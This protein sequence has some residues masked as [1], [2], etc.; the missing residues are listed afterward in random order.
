M[1]SWH[2]F[3]SFSGHICNTL[4]CINL[5]RLKALVNSALSPRR[6]DDAAELLWSPGHS[7]EWSR[8]NISGVHLRW[9]GA[10][11][12]SGIS[13]CTGRV[14]L[15]GLS[16]TVL[17]HLC[18]IKH[19][20]PPRP[21]PR[22]HTHTTRCVEYVTCVPLSL[23]HQDERAS[24]MHELRCAL[25]SE[26]RQGKFKHVCDHPSD[27]ESVN[28]SSVWMNSSDLNSCEE[29]LWGYECYSAAAVPPVTGDELSLSHTA[30]MF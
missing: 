23:Y 2:T 18:M 9:R 7:T 13:S 16:R 29:T 26:S 10:C 28:F 25:A 27:R 8:E 20:G 4:W 3:T 1:E 21:P 14:Q 17:S 12:R 5:T 15:G 22:T 24:G 11:P 19:P 30:Q 6:S